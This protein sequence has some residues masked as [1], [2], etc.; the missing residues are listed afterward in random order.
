METKV[1]NT[2]TVI[3]D[4]SA[5]AQRLIESAKKDK[6]TLQIVAPVELPKEVENLK[7]KFNALSPEEKRMLLKEVKPEKKERTQTRMDCVC[8]VLKDKKPATIAEWVTATN[9]LFGNTNDQE[10]LANIR[11]A[12]RVLKHFDVAT[13]EK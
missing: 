13:P 10:S 8:Q 4:K 7:A 6:T 11:C 2:R 9:E 3:S 12:I 1:A 5:K